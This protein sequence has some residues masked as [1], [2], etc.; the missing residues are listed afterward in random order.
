MDKEQVNETEE[1][2]GESRKPVLEGAPPPTAG[3]AK[4]YILTRKALPYYDKSHNH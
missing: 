4:D 2:A 3:A 1:H